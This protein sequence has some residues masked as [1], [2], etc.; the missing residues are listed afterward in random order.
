V[1][2]LARPAYFVYAIW[3]PANKAYAK[4][5][6]EVPLARP[7]KFPI[8]KLIGFDQETIDALDSYRRDQAAIPN[9]LISTEK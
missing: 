6:K 2:T 3:A 7:E 1:R 8:K 4:Y 9:M 5:A